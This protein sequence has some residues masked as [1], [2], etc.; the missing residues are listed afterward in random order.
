ME[1]EL[2][3]K[4]EV[5]SAFSVHLLR[6]NS[7]GREVAI[8]GLWPQVASVCIQLHLFLARYLICKLGIMKI[9]ISQGGCDIKM[10]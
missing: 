5:C 8:A 10:R 2:L 9:Y 6:Q 4:R 3:V 7:A 1:V